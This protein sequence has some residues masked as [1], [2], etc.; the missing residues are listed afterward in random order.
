MLYFMSL[1]V[2]DDQTCDSHT[3]WKPLCRMAYAERRIQYDGYSGN[4]GLHFHPSF[5]HF[6]LVTI[7]ERV[8]LEN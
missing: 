7:L 8:V 6:T 1:F 5:S 4:I 2:F 3:E